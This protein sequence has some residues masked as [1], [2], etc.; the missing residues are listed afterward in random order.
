MLYRL[1]SLVMNKIKEL[2]KDVS[3]DYQHIQR[4]RDLAKII[5]INIKADLYIVDVIALLHEIDNVEELLASVGFN[6]IPRI[7]SL[8]KFIGYSTGPLRKNGINLSKEDFDIVSCVSDADNLDALGSIGIARVFAYCGYFKIDISN[9]V[10]PEYEHS[11][12]NYRKSKCSSGINVFFEKIIH[13]PDYII[14][15]IGKN[16][17]EKRIAIVLIFLDSFAEETG[18]R[19]LKHI[20]DKVKPKYNI[21]SSKSHPTYNNYTFYLKDVTFVIGWEREYNKLVPNGY[22]AFIN[23]KFIIRFPLDMDSK[24]VDGY[25]DTN[26]PFTRKKYYT[27]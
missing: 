23:D 3:H 7:S 16:I 20:Y 2:H 24:V 14:T 12:E 18:H 10:I 26:I 8:I 5:A 27:K 9:G 25:L 22:V 15:N 17:A 11:F 4:V 1:E 21:S 6:Q 19:Y 13:I